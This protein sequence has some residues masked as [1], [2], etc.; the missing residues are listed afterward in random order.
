MLTYIY[1]TYTVNPQPNTEVFEKA[2]QHGG[3]KSNFSNHFVN[4]QFQPLK[5]ILRKPLVLEG[6]NGR[7]LKINEIVNGAIVNGL[8][9]Y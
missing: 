6:K 2:V 7:S 5:S 9:Q 1:F 3:M 4:D 8:L